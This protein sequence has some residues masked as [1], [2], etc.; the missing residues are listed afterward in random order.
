M[1]SLPDTKSGLR[2]VLKQCIDD[3]EFFAQ[4]QLKIKTKAGGTAPLVLNRAQKY[5]H[6]QLEQQLFEQGQVRALVLKGRQ[7]GVST[8]TEARFYWKAIFRRA[9][10]V[11]I[12]THEDAATQNLFAM[13][14]HYHRNLHPLLR[15]ATS[16]DNA[17][18]LTFLRN[19]SGYKVSTA[20]NKGTGRSA[21]VHYCHGS[22]AA[23]WPHAESH[24][25]GLLQAVPEGGETEVV[26]ESTGNGIGGFFHNQWQ[27]AEAGESEY[28]A[29]FVPWYWQ[30]EYQKEAP[31]DWNPS[32]SEL[33]YVD[34]YELSREQ[35]YWMHAK[36]MDLGGDAGE[37]G[38]Q[39]LQEY[40]FT[41]SDAFQTSGDDSICHPHDVAAAR[42]CTITRKQE[43]AHVMGVDPARYGNDRSSW[44]HRNRRVAWG[45]KSFRKI[46]TTELA[47]RV[48]REIE[49]CA[50]EGDPVDAVF[51]DVVGLGAGVVDTLND[52][53][54]QHIVIPVDAGS[55]ADDPEEFF[56]KRAEMWAI[57]GQWFADAPVSIDDLDSLH[58]D[59]IAPSYTYN[60]KQQLVL[61]T[62]E[63]MSKRGIR[64][65][66]EAEAL[67]LTHAYPVRPK[68]STQ[69]RRKG[70][71]PLNWKA[72]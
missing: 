45:T 65:P 28:I 42:R 5:I 30:E 67:A 27:K 63:Q 15:P 29:V 54:Y 70:P 18:E 36:N 10:K 69:A 19:G 3:F 44:V 72:M 52:M 59:L 48:A 6:D 57:L 40:P 55:K 16:R 58:A 33:W 47:A 64:S 4:R 24:A 7:Q 56:N 17:K 13:V 20:G 41:A 51:V 23:Y 21:T 61:E 53:G 2:T 66:D 12:L 71:R 38:W 34:N 14:E 39:F 25:A 26:L 46:S 60:T 50:D 11:F 62:K 43:G 37:I 8:Y 9:V 31:R 32:A 49:R 35:S 1:T 68:R 22:E